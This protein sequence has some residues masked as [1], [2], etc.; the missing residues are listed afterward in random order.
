M[1]YVPKYYTEIVHTQ[2]TIK[3]WLENY[4]RNLELTP[5][6]Q[7]LDV[8]TSKK[9]NKGTV[10]ATKRQSI[11]GDIFEGLY[12]GE[13]CAYNLTKADIELYKRDYKVYNVK[14]KAIHDGGHRARAI[15]NYY[16]GKF[17][18][19]KSNQIG[20]K[21]YNELT[22]EEREFF[23][24]VNILM[25]EFVNSSPEF[26]GRQFHKA[27]MSTMLNNQEICNGYGN[28]P[29]ANVIRKKARNLGA[30][31][32]NCPH[33]LFTVDYDKDGNPRGRYL[34]AKGPARL[35]Y[36]RFVARV[37]YCVLKDKP[38]PCDDV[39]I[40]E[41]YGDKNIIHK[42]VKDHEKRLDDALTFIW[43]IAN[44]ARL[45]SSARKIMDF[46][47]AAMLKR[48]YFT[49]RSECGV[50]FHLQ[51]PDEFW[52]EFST[53]YFNARNDITILKETNGTAGQMFGKKL[54]TH[55]N[56]E[57]WKYTIDAMARQGFTLAKLIEN[58]VVVLSGKGSRG[59]SVNMIYRK[60]IENGRLDGVDGKPLRFE[61][62]V[63]AHIIPHSK[64]GNTEYS[65]LE[66]TSEE[67]NRKMGTMNL[68]DYK[69]SLNLESS[70]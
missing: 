55:K 56:L 41:M 61:N 53:A 35:G 24:N 16:N 3:E 65:N 7:R 25:T 58:E 11:I 70:K 44:A 45:D 30:G 13:L 36:D 50:D 31:I 32:D 15:V 68:Q 43:K 47:Q 10:V 2:L 34:S 48:F 69:A 14:L 38:S 46:E 26:R 1:A 19:H 12:I 59:F 28:I 20:A 17:P 52:R 39:E 64:N 5:V 33:N 62:A 54:R 4:I 57:D 27:G 22:D 63:G 49:W 42:T 29:V 51:N 18:T 8:Q 40:V 23:L 6:E 66:V 9:E 21:Y 67:H 37:M 60:W